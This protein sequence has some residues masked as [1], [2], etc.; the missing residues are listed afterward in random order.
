MEII[1][2]QSV[3]VTFNSDLDL[4]AYEKVIYAYSYPSKVEFVPTITAS[5]H[6][7]SCVWTPVQ[8]ALMPSGKMYISIKLKNSGNAAIGR[9]ELGSLIS[10]KS[11]IITDQSSVSAAIT[12]QM[13]VGSVAAFDL[14]I[15][16]DIVVQQIGSTNTI[17][18]TAQ[19]L[20]APQKVQAR[21]NIE[22]EQEGTAANLISG[23]VSA[24][25]TAITAAINSMING[26]SS[27]YN[28]LKK[29]QTELEL[30]DSQFNAFK[31]QFLT[32]E[33]GE[34]ILDINNNIITT[35]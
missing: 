17:L 22:A 12:L 5:A 31:N 8:T 9:L 14:K 4:T 29:I 28:T 2:G 23:E 21:A 33:A 3:A 7:I 19:T 13:N 35:I 24:R 16:N 26:A 20:T 10:K 6:L 18:F 30:D 34:L 1:K 11:P 27:A 32:T 25:N 15:G